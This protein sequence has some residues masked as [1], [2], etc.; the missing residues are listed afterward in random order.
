M[1]KM[2]IAFLTK[3]RVDLSK[4]TIVPLLQPDKF[5]TF[6]IDGSDTLTGMRFAG[7]YMEEG[8][9]D[10]VHINVKGGAD[11]A[12]VYAL[13]EMLKGDYTHV[14]LVENDVLLHPDWFG[15]TMALFERGAADG[16]AVGAVSA[17][18]YV[19]RL[20]CQ[21][22][23]YALVHNLGWG[24]QI[25][26]RQAAELTLKHFRTHWTTE[27]RRTFARLSGI[28]IGS[29]WAFRTNDHWT[30]P[31]WGNDA[32]LA[33]NGLASLALVPSPVE[34]IGQ[35]PSLADQ[36]LKLADAPVE[37]R[38]N[39]A[40]FAEFKDATAAL[41]ASDFDIGGP[42]VRF[43]GDDG[44]QIVFAHQ[45]DSLDRAFWSGDWRLKWSPG[46]GGFAARGF[47][48]KATMEFSSNEN[49]NGAQFECCASGTARFM[50]MGGEKG[51][52]IQIEDTKSGYVVRPTLLP[53]ASNQV[54]Q[55]VAPTGVSW[56]LLRL[57]VLSGSALLYG[58]QF[59][60]AQPTV[61]GW[62]FDH[63]KLW[64]A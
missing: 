16:L 49:S 43:R 19:D 47:G 29:Y 17:R 14:G 36:G 60:E 62:K 52:Q 3:D 63:S 51:G 18:A 4:R 33:S 44:T 48:P 5:T 11:T 55:V 58:M 23:G 40:A 12:V 6:I 57:T 8:K 59:Q 46:L 13:T 10:H 37:D 27:N 56:R 32:V 35:K 25:L 42:P 38:R 45:L 2:A 30:T 64:L 9:P 22:D 7:D 34:M 20:L 54:T 28:D 53:E 24:M 15:P 21:R 31:D 61:G 26:T 1:H 39:D 50:V 41:R